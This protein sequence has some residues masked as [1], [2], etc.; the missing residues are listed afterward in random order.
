MCILV[1]VRRPTE[2][3][4]SPSLGLPEPPRAI[5]RCTYGIPPS[6][7]MAMV[8]SAVL[9]TLPDEGPHSSFPATSSTILGRGEGVSIGLDI[10]CGSLSSINGWKGEDGERGRRKR[11]A[12]EG[13]ERGSQSA[14]S[15]TLKGVRWA[16]IWLVRV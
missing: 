16:L 3:Y 6:L 7:S 8:M 12:K 13:G 14:S 9:W 15:Q 2:D 4:D 5:I 11:A 10:E 1:L